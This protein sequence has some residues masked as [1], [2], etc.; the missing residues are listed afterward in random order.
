ERRG[1]RHEGGRGER[2][3]VDAGHP[4]AKPVRDEAPRRR[5]GRARGRHVR[6]RHRPGD[7]PRSLRTHQHLAV[8]TK[9]AMRAVLTP[10][11]ATAGTGHGAALGLPA[12]DLDALVAYLRS[13][14]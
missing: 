1:L 9:D 6:R 4:R 3:P 12:S 14:W 8:A 2:A 13:L 10:P 7:L 11:L 5:H